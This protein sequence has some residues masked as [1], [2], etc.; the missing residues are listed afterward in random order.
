MK[1]SELISK[2][3]CSKNFLLVAGLVNA[4]PENRKVLLNI[5]HHDSKLPVID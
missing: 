1:V 5:N 4:F 2:F 3:N